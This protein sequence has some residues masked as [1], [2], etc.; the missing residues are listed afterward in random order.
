[1]KTVKYPV[2]NHDNYHAHVYFDQETLEVAE[3]LCNKASELFM[4]KVGRLHH[5]AVGPHSKWSCQITFSSHD[6]EQFIP[7]LDNNRQGLN[8]LVHALTDD[9]LKDHTEYACW[10]GNKVRLNLEIF[11]P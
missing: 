9:N 6:F 5:N 3:S 8:I 4:L 1:M 11:Q 2:N 10:L 7:W